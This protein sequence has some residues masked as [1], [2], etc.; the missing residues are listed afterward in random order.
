MKQTKSSTSNNFG[1]WGWSMILYAAVSYYLASAL[2]ADLLNFF[3]A[4]FEAL[5]GWNSG[6]ITTMAGLA[7][8]VGVI[9]AIV[10]AQVIAKIGTRNMAVISNIVTGVLV[11][12]F[13]NITSFTGF[14]ILLFCIITI[15]GSVQV[16]LVPN[17]LMAMWFPKKKGIALGWATM[18]MPICS[19]TIV[20]L[21]SFLTKQLGSI[22]GAFTVFGIVIIVYGVISFFWVKNSPESVG[23]YPDNEVTSPEELE[24]N[25]RKLENHV[26]PW[27]FGKLLKCPSTWGI[28]LGL[29]LLWMTTSGIISQLVPRLMTVADG[30]YASYAIATM[31]IA[32]VIGIFGSYMWGWL[33]QKFGTKFTCYLYGF[34]Y[35]AAL[36]FMILQ[37][38]GAAFVWISVVMVGIGIGGIGNLIPSLI[39]TSFGRYDFVQANKVI[40]PINT[41]VRCA[42]IILAGIF[43]QTVWGYTGLYILL[44]VMSLIGLLLIKFLVK[45]QGSSAQ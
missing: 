4:Q 27:T 11:I 45:D 34:W 43:S 28:G 3:P 7:G 26:S 16:N 44:I 5:R 6:V 42:G 9:G 30:A 2:G 25:K 8:W 10:F 29:G 36:I 15:A 19:A 37:A 13:A 31:S 38:Y 12:L 17:N 39:T 18:G 1:K 22:S 41:I 20:L 33:D 23:C 35:V 21:F 40:A 14:I 24:A 32:A